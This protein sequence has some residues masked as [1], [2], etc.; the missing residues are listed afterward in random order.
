MNTTPILHL[1]M[2]RERK[3]S[4]GYSCLLCHLLCSLP[5]FIGRVHQGFVLGPLFCLVIPLVIS[6]TSMALNAVSMLTTPKVMS[7]SDLSILAYPATLICPVHHPIGVIDI[8]SKTELL[9]SPPHCP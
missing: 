7:S 8:T 6:C 1:G 2:W 3:R 9:I 5:P 4:N